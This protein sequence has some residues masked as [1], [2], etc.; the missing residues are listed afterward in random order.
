MASDG[1]HI[2]NGTTG[3]PKRERPKRILATPID[4]ILKSSGEGNILQIGF[5]V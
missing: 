3:G 5:F 1:R 2:F 4:K